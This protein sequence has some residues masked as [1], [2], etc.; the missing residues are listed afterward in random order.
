VLY[1]VYGALVVYGFVVWLK[2]SATESQPTPE[3]VAA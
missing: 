2:A 3:E 1:V